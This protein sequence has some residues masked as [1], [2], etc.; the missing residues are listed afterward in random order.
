MTV[1]IF[2]NFHTVNPRPSHLLCTV[3]TCRKRLESARKKITDIHWW[4][5]WESNKTREC[6]GPYF[7]WPPNDW[8]NLPSSVQTQSQ[9]QTQI[10]LHLSALLSLRKCPVGQEMFHSSFFKVKP[11]TGKKC[12]MIRKGWGSSYNL[13]LRVFS[14][15]RMPRLIGQFCRQNLLSKAEFRATSRTSLPNEQNWAESGQ[16]EYVIPFHTISSVVV[17]TILPP[18]PEILWI[19]LGGKPKWLPLNPGY[20]D[21]MRTSPIFQ[22]QQNNFQQI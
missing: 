4:S 10:Y 9:T 18:I 7:S 21:V 3:C 20:H 12:C 15:L 1:F 11:P 5:Q 8:G 6:I 17:H 2:H 13:F 16:C 19:E 14:G 22:N